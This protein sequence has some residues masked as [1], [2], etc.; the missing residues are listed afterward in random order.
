MQK[1][2][3]PTRRK[4][5][6]QKPDQYTEQARIYL[7][8][9]FNARTPALVRDVISSWITQLESATQ[10]LFN[11]QDVLAVALPKMLKRAAQLGVAVD[12]LEHGIALNALR[13]S[14]SVEETGR[15]LKDDDAI[16]ACYILTDEIE[17]D[18]A[19][20]AR[21]VNSPRIP[22]SIKVPFHS[23]VLEITDA[24]DSAPEVM[25]VQWPLALRDL[26]A[27]EKGGE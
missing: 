6:S 11:D 7:S 14:V 20:I 24:V 3:T 16:T 25:R 17:Q 10:V 21:I 5:S 22:D 12:D 26:A 23:S 19:A 9:Y 27:H 13:E 4:G 8:L 2:D 1:K 18:A 15:A